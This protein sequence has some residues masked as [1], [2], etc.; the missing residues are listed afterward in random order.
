MFKT[1]NSARVCHNDIL[2]LGVQT[3]VYMNGVSI[4]PER[5]KKVSYTYLNKIKFISNDI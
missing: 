2:I 5:Q 4:N 3:S 1:L